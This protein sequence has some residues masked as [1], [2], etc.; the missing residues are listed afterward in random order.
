MP[1]PRLGTSCSAGCVA[2]D[3]KTVNRRRQRRQS[4]R[5]PRDSYESRS[6]PHSLSTRFPQGLSSLTTDHNSRT[7]LSTGPSLRNHGDHVIFDPRRELAR[8]LQCKELVGG[9]GGPQGK[10]DLAIAEGAT[11]RQ[12]QV[13][14][15]AQ[16]GSLGRDQPTS[17]LERRR[18]RESTTATDF[19]E[20]HGRQAM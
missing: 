17:I 4:R 12:W 8:T 9:R 11:P 16:G 5:K 19:L 3:L 10:A 20:G 13:K 18:P 2:A 6:H 15:L 7:D 14:N 1:R